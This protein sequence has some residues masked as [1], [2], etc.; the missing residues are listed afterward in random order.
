MDSSI[1]ITIGIFLSVCLYF[2]IALRCQKLNI[3]PS[4]FFYS[5]L[6]ISGLHYGNS[7]AGA[8]ITF[9]SI[10]IFLCS[11]A[12]ISGWSTIFASIFWAI[13]V[14]LFVILVDKLEISFQK[15]QTLH[16]FLSELYNNP[17]LQITASIITIFAFT[18]TIGIEFLGFSWFLKYFGVSTQ[19]TI[20]IGLVLVIM[21]AIYTIIGGYWATIKTDFFQVL[22][23]LIGC[24]LLLSFFLPIHPKDAN[25]DHFNNIKVLLNSFSI[26]QLFY[27]PPLIMGF[28]ILFIPFQF[29]VMDIWQRG[30]AAG[31]DK[32]KI[33]KYTLC[34][35]LFLSVVFSLPVILG[36]FAIN[37]KLVNPAQND[38]LFV[39]VKSLSNPYVI[40]AIGVMFLASIFSTADTL[41]LAA[42]NSAICDIYSYQNDDSITAHNINNS[43]IQ[44]STCF[45]AVL[46]LSLISL[47]IFLV[48]MLPI[49]ISELIVAVF[50]AQ[51]IIGVLIIYAIL[52]PN[53]AQI[54]GKGA[55]YSSILGL[56]MPIPLVIIGKL[57]E[58][59]NI[60]NGAPLL[61]III[62]VII[63]FAY[64][65]D[66]E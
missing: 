10:F 5:D 63:L 17:K 61:S 3:N 66:K 36:I 20:F 1:A 39:L 52:F 46:S 55:L 40:S 53:K 26:E 24:L 18:G 45:Y 35:G 34:S 64:P 21:L 54:M 44:M 32:D 62:A 4:D 37:S 28:A 27:D 33:K 42:A 56:I 41:L 15:G 13:G 8:N 29:S 49:G 25:I 12:T 14:I 11:Q 47:I 7:Y 23:T 9:T 50:S 16:F 38:T 48:A 43:K 31:G 2:F 58:D 57:V 30:V 19:S 60:I 22:F 65:K 59:N 51:S 6:K